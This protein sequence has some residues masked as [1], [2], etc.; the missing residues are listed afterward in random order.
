MLDEDSYFKDPETGSP[1]VGVE[2]QPPANPETLFQEMRF[3]SSR[4]SGIFP[5]VGFVYP[6]KGGRYRGRSP[7]FWVVVSVL[8]NERCP[9]DL[10]GAKVVMLGYNELGEI[11]SSQTYNAICLYDRK[12]AGVVDVNLCLTPRQI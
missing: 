12:L 11:C 7:Q 6:A 8:K 5:E 3:R 4:G 1:V 9:D 2:R 10:M